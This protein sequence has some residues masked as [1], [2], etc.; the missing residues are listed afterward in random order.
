MPTDISVIKNLIIQGWYGRQ[1]VCTGTLVDI[2]SGNQFVLGWKTDKDKYILDVK[3]NAVYHQ[4]FIGTKR[5][6]PVYRKRIHT[7]KGTWIVI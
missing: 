2:S 1:E 6:I 7:I 5:I 4:K 3:D